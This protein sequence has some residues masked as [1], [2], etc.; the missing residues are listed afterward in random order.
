MYQCN[1]SFYR[2]NEGFNYQMGEVINETDF[3]KIP[4][5]YKKWFT[6][7]G[8]PLHFYCQN[9]CGDVNFSFEEWDKAYEEVKIFSNEI[10]EIALATPPACKEQCF[11]CFSIV[12]DR[13]LKTKKLNSCTVSP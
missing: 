3:N 6:Q 10:R 12:A 8:K 5:K 11:A 2:P 7:I 13:R 4:T 9:I 1:N